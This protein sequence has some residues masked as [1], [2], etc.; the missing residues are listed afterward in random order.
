MTY[1]LKLDIYE[2]PLDLLLY[3]IKK[4][5]LDI[6]SIAIA[7]VTDQYIEYINMLQLL[8]LN[9][10]GEFLVTAATLMQIKS[11]A[12]LPP[13]P[14]AKE[15]APPD[16]ADELVQRLLEYQR[17]KEIAE[18]LKTKESA[19]QDFFSRNVSEDE[20]NK[21]KDESK[22]T[23]IEASLFDLINAFSRA[24]TRVPEKKDYEITKEEYTVD[25]KV[26][27]VLHLL[28]EQSRLSL[29]DLFCKAQ[30]R[31]EM[32]V[33]FLAVL[34]LIRLREIV[35]MQPRNF[36]DVEIIRN[37]E[38]EVSTVSTQDQPSTK[39]AIPD[40]GSPEASPQSGNG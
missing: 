13:D 35:V 27:M 34:E 7:E 4:N 36:E 25:Q 3:L 24:L 26:H 29:N 8:D 15:D 18:Q 28:I 10:V 30:H 2:G 39:E 17:Y 21:L 9:I 31:L 6:C 11:R 5:E 38:H 33:T 37:K 32:I 14:L 16:P 22:E 40:G 19:R 23:Y 12:L 1:K 20:L